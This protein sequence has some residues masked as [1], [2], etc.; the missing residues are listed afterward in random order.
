MYKIPV[1]LRHKRA[2]VSLGPSC[3]EVETEIVVASTKHCSGACGL[4]ELDAL[5]GLRQMLAF[6][7]ACPLGELELEVYE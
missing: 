5:G 3:P 1:F 6:L 2:K 4:T 7:Y